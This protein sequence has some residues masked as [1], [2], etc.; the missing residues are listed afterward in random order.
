MLIGEKMGKKLDSLH[1]NSYH[2]EERFIALLLP[3][4]TEYQRPPSPYSEV[5]VTR[6]MTYTREQSLGVTDQ[7]LS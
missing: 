5:P 7:C 3:Q 2:G 1:L 4:M 6:C